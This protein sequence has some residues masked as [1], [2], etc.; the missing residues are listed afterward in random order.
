MHSPALVLE[1]CLSFGEIERSIKP[2]FLGLVYE[3]PTEFVL[4]VGMLLLAVPRP[5]SMKRSCIFVFQDSH[6]AQALESDG[7]KYHHDHENRHP[8]DY[9]DRQRY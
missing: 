9:G 4:L 7:E 2:A 3:V 8:G 5:I 6:L 1:Q